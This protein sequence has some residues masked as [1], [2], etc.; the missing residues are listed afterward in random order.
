M[1][2]ILRIFGT[3]ALLGMLAT[4][5]PENAAQLQL[6]TGAPYLCAVG[7]IG[8]KS[9]ARLPPPGGWTSSTCVNGHYRA[10]QSTTFWV[11]GRHLLY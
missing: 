10:A 2:H 3:V 7:A 5:D 11:G 9:N 1:S 6:N 4:F 8:F